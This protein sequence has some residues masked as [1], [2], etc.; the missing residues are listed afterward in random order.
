MNSLYGRFRINP[1]STITEMC[2]FKRYTDVVSFE[3]FIHGDMLIENNFIESYHTNTRNDETHW[4]PPKNSAIQVAAAITASTRIYM[5]HY[6]SRDDCYYTDTDS[7]VLSQ[8]FPEELISSSILGM[9]KLEDQIMKGFE[10]T[11]SQL[12]TDHSTTELLRNN[13][14]KEV[15]SGSLDQPMT[16]QKGVRHPHIHREKDYDS[17]PLPGRRASR[18]RRRRST[19]HSRDSY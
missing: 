5:Y 14:L 19:I 7:V 12:T 13:R 10:P 16:K 3:G 4:N 11:T 6:I 8:P 18:T 17:K 15:D 9:L 1:K 2:N